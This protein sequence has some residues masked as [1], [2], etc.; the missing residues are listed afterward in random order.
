MR[1]YLKK[2]SVIAGFSLIEL[3]V[4]I[5][6]IGI[7]A[8]MLVPALA[9]AKQS[10]RSAHCKNNLRQLGIASL[11]YSQESEDDLP[12]SAHGGH[13]WL[14]SLFPYTGT[15][16]FRCL[17][18]RAVQRLYS[19]A[20]NDFLVHG[21]V[22]GQDFSHRL[23]IPAPSATLFMAE[24]SDKYRGG[25]HFHFADRFDGGYTPGAFDAQV[26]T[27]RHLESSNYLYVDSHVESHKPGRVHIYLTNHMSRFI[28]PLG[29][30][31]TSIKSTLP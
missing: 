7:L 30:S 6:V 25:D 5:V 23:K 11:L 17:D 16:V 29:H 14:A 13:S 24:K 27:K 28:N 31:N 22:P 2:R 15:N 12:G 18:D 3:L 4:V 21:L 26:A 8:S 20:L 1:M 19:Y 9:K 10:A